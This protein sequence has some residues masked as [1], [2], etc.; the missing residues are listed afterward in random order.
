MNKS[1]PKTKDV[2]EPGIYDAKN[3]HAGLKDAMDP[4]KSIKNQAVDTKC[5]G[6]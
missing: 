4:K 6:C 2:S 5:E 1:G 3:P